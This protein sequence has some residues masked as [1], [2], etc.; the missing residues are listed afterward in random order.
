M[1]KAKGLDNMSID[2]LLVGVLDITLKD[3]TSIEQWVKDQGLR[4]GTAR[5]AVQDLYDS[6]CDW[7][8][9]H[10]DIVTQLVGIARFARNIQQ[11]GR[12]VRGKR[13]TFY[14]VHWP[15]RGLGQPNQNGGRSVSEA[16]RESAGDSEGG[17]EG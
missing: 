3:P 1:V 4:P 7:A 13:G 17:D 14:Y 5:V 6:Y 9:Q 16:L 11:I 2:E 8:A 15:V 10:S 12:R